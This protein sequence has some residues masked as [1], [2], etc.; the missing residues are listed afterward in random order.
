MHTSSSPVLPPLSAPSFLGSRASDIAETPPRS[1]GTQYYTA[2]WGS[3]YQHPAPTGRGSRSH[4]HYQSLSSDASSDSPIHHLDFPDHY[5][6]PVA[7]FNRSH[8]NPEH[9]SN[10]SLAAVLANRARGPLRALTQD[11]IDLHTKGVSTEAGHWL[12]DD[13]G[14][15]EH[16]SLS[17]SISGED[18]QWLDQDFDPRTPT[19]K[20]FQK[21]A[22]R[23]G[24]RRQ[25]STKTLRPSDFS[26]LVI[27]T[28]DSMSTTDENSRGGA[29]SPTASIEDRP[30]PLPSEDNAPWRA[31][32]IPSSPIESRERASTPVS[33]PRLK[34]KVPWKGKNIMVLLPMD[35]ERGKRGKAP[36]PMSEHDVGAMLRDWGQLGYDTSGFNLG[37][38]SDEDA[39]LGQSRCIWPTAADINFERARRAFRVSIPDRRRKLILYMG[40]LFESARFGRE[41]V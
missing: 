25:E 30:P 37:Y 39:G 14:D 40:L 32:A 4:S 2:S 36:A 27:T 6:R 23:R 7:T 28:N 13:A 3:P 35:D 11:W 34:K 24:H 19:I 15:S 38:T 41:G 8:T 1:A 5:L 10:D 31:T 17:G 16:S 22:R 20:R 18:T 33:P 29:D 26:D 9:T 12:S 21:R